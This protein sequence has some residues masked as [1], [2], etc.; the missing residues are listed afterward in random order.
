MGGWTIAPTGS[1]ENIVQLVL[2]TGWFW[3]ITQFGATVNFR[4]PVTLFLMVHS[5]MAP[6]VDVISVTRKLLEIIELPR[7]INTVHL[8][9]PSMITCWAVNVKFHSSPG[10]KPRTEALRLSR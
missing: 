2:N 6:K 5:G 9:E 7:F 4:S 8:G 10:L 3:T 1:F